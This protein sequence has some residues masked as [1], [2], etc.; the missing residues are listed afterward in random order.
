MTSHCAVVAA[1]AM[2]A[3]ADT[4]PLLQVSFFGE[5]IDH[6][7]QPGQLA[8]ALCMGKRMCHASAAL[9][10]SVPGTLLL[11]RAPPKPCAEGNPT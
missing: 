6:K 5:K 9:P 7:V 8:S 1:I 2:S 3:L 4:D 11:Q 10:Q